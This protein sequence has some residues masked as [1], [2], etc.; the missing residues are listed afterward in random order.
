MVLAGPG[1]GKT[2]TL[3]ARHSF[4][5]SRGRDPLGIIAITF[6]QKAAEELKERIG[7]KAPPQAWIGTF[8]GLC[9]RLLKRFSEEAGLRKSFKILDPKGQRKLLTDIGI[10]WD[11]DDGDLIDIIGRWKDSLISPDEAGGM[12]FAPGD[13]GNSTMQIAAEHYAAYEAELDRRGDLDFADLVVMG[14][15]L[16]ESS[17]PVRDFMKT[18]FTDILVDEFQDVNRVQ[19]EFVMAIA[20]LGIN[21]WAVADDDQALYGWRGGDVRLTVDFSKHFKGATYYKLTEN[22]RCDPAILA[23]AMTLI[24]RNKVRIAKNLR[25]VRPHSPQNIVRMR[26]FANE[27]DEACWIADAVHRSLNSGTQPSELCILF[28]T[29]SVAPAIQ[30]AFERLRVPFALTGAVSFW[31]TPEMTVVIDLLTEIESGNPGYAAA[32]SRECRELV[33]RLK[34]DGPTATAGLVSEALRDRAP[35]GSSTERAASW[36]DLVEAS[37]AV[38][39]K[40]ATTG[41]FKRHVLEMT[42]RSS[43]G[44]SDAVA[45]STIHSSKGLEWRHIFVAGCEASMMPHHRSRDIEEERRLL[46]VALT[47]SKGAVDLTFA[48][49]RFGRAQAPS[50]FLSEIASTGGGAAAWVG[51][52]PAPATAGAAAPAAKETAASVNAM[53]EAGPKVYRRRGGR[54]LIP[55]G[56]S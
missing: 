28:R 9:T 52:E 29:A 33:A 49:S 19:C 3:V 27:Q 45:L 11:A 38:A 34:G 35:P 12:M 2:S 47:R 16:I 40:F 20:N 17:E 39:A 15:K 31:E 50:P 55:P 44:S 4:L 42:A 51:G 43:V 24:G 1:T 36:F 7:D 53:T 13:A 48:R 21:V 25:A 30:Q 32:R 46:Y 14:W 54:S 23:A 26:G 8:H 41:D 22:Y 10:K 5:R 56:E 18:R 37:C 6:T